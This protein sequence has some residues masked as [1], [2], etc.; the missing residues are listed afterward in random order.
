MRNTAN[1]I[2]KLLDAFTINDTVVLNSDFT[3]YELDIIIWYADAKLLQSVLQI[4]DLFLGLIDQ[5]DITLTK[6]QLYQLDDI[7]DN[8]YIYDNEEVSL[9]ILNYFTNLQKL[10]QKKLQIS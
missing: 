8:E 3:G 4:F 9:Y 6:D 10:S 1:D 5:Y 2:I 7:L